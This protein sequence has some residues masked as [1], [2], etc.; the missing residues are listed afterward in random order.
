MY[1]QGSVTSR[2]FFINGIRIWI[3]FL[4]IF[5]AMVETRMANSRKLIC[6]RIASPITM[7]FWYVSVSDDQDA[8]YDY[9][10]QVGPVT[11]TISQTALS[12][13][14]VFFQR[15]GEEIFL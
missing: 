1:D 7:R 4:D 9:F 6:Y 14:E 15:Q 3:D 11:I 5:G 12:G 2:F 8:G 10:L 13:L